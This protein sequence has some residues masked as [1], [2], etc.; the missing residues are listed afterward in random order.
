M[1]RQD[2]LRDSSDRAKHDGSKRWNFPARQHE[3]ADSCISGVCLGKNRTGADWRVQC[4]RQQAD[5]SAPLY[6]CGNLLRVAARVASVE[7]RGFFPL[8]RRDGRE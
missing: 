6:G 8:C 5:D 1:N 7:G 2:R 3:K 4:A